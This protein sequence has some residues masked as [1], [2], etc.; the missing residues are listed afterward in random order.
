MLYTRE[1]TPKDQMQICSYKFSAVLQKN[2]ECLQ[3]SLSSLEDVEGQNREEKKNK[4]VRCNPARV[5]AK[6]SD[7]IEAIEGLYLAK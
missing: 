1:A 4:S 2:Q 7:L 6:S 3:D 5:L